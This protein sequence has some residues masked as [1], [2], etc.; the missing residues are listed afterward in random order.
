MTI[1]ITI[2]RLVQVPR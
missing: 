1:L 2:V